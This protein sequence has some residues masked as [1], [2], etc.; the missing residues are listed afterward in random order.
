M[1]NVDLSYA[2]DVLSYRFGGDDD[3]NEAEACLSVYSRPVC[4]AKTGLE[5]LPELPDVHFCMHWGVKVEF[6]QS[7]K[8]LGRCIYTFDADAQKKGDLCKTDF[9]EL[10]KALMAGEFMVTGFEYYPDQKDSKYATK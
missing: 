8:G 7:S 9:T 2:R 5:S 4:R 6:K 1:A 10:L 3:W